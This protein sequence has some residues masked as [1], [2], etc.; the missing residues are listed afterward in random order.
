MGNAA[1]VA[2]V[3]E[4]V[5]KHLPTRHDQKTHG[6]VR[7]ARSVV[8]A[9]RIELHPRIDEVAQMSGS[10]H[11]LRYRGCLKNAKRI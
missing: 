10:C 8:E 5:I 2:K 3:V 7:D 1:N 6:G 11:L 9:E 4:E